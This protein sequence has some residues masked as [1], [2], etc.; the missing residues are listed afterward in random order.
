MTRR[1]LASVGALICLF[2]LLSGCSRTLYRLR[3]DKEVK[4]LVTQKSNDERW[5]FRDFTIGMDPRS[6]YFDPNDPDCP[7]MPYDDPAAHRYMHCAAGRKGYPCWHMNGDNAPI[8]NP[9]WKELL[10]QYNELTPEGA[11]K[12]T[13]NGSVCLAQVHSDSWRDQIENIYLSALDVSAER[14]SFDAQFFGDSST[15]FNH[16]GPANSPAGEQNTLT[17]GGAGSSL[18]GSGVAG[19]PGAATFA[20]TKQFT[21]GATLLVGFANAFVWQ[22]AGHD[23]NQASSL[24][25]VA[26]MQP[27][28]RNG[29]RQ[30][31]MEVL[32]R[33]ERNLLY[34]LRQWERYRQSFYC[35]ATVGLQGASG[36]QAVTRQGGLLGGSGLTGFTG[37]GA[38]GQGGIGVLVS[39]G[40]TGIGGAGGIGTGAG[41]AGGGAGSVG[42]FV[43]LI[44]QLYGVRVV[45]HNVNALNR[46]LGLLEANL[47][48]GLIDIVQV[49][50]FR[51][52]IETQR[53]ALI[54]AQLQFQANLD[55]FKT[56]IMTL[57]P[58]LSI[59]IDDSMLRPF[60]FLDPRTTAVQYMVD[61]FV[62]VLGQLPKEP[63]R[64]DVASAIDVLSQLRTRIVGQF[65]GANADVA[66]LETK[67]ETRKAAMD[68][69]AAE[70]FDTER[71][72][73]R[74]SLADVEKRFN[75]A[76]KVL[77]SLPGRLGS[78]SMA[79]VTDQLVG[80]ATDLSGLTQELLLIKARARVESVTTPSIKLASEDALQIARVN[81]LDW[82]NQRA[83]LVDSW[84][85]IAF[86]AQ[87]LKAGVNLTF[88]GG[89]GTLGNNA[90]NFNGNT[91]DLRVGV[92]FDAPLTRRLERN[93][94]RIALIGYQSQRRVTYQFEDSVNFVLR[95]LLRTLQFLEIDLEIQRRAVVIAIRRVD[96]TREDLTR[97]PAPVQPG[98]QV[99]ALGPTVAQNLIFALN[100]LQNAQNA[101]ISVVLNHYE[102]RMLL[103]REL[104][105]M[106]LDNCGMW[107][108]KPF[109]SAEWLNRDN[110]ND[111][112]LPP[113]VPV[114]W[115]QD[116]GVSLE[117]IHEFEAE[118]AG[119]TPEAR[120]AALKEAAD[121]AWESSGISK[122]AR[123]LRLMPNEAWSVKP[124]G[125]T[126]TKNP[127]ETETKPSSVHTKKNEAEPSPPP[128]AGVSESSPPTH[129]TTITKRAQAPRRAMPIAPLALGN[130]GERE[131]SDMAVPAL[132]R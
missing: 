73:L 59:E 17:V 49:D 52:N 25:N 42:G 128:P 56:G 80:L 3:A 119:D 60:E 6:R 121:V 44:Q 129:G 28:L 77:D 71:G 130:E 2:L 27:L 18:A 4:Y 111:C 118:H 50:N 112:A 81:R 74:E 69:R 113:A 110:E 32:T 31:V 66:K 79:Q 97:P 14:F 127:H 109:N 46:T 106:E 76:Q 53:A 23:T 102:N 89:I 65:R 122:N 7:A 64:Q 125:A 10:G 104:G 85:L 15:V 90:V 35:L 99:E 22:F 39:A 114:E 24:L 34:D 68:A 86:N 16:S 19:A 40:A 98:Q 57:P 105:I 67:A 47:D 92:A 75:I 115:L 48:A 62:H 26:F 5:D 55:N 100:D 78:E 45:Q 117:D 30:L 120:L 132:R 107:I 41:F 91:G 101:F 72:K 58:D 8:E 116:A 83:A 87:Q 29:G 94:Y 84:R 82:M 70:S 123:P 126:T 63:Q 33:V 93:N 124:L 61:D 51:Q 43:G 1:T 95:N 12:L 37:Q 54:T 21:T 96:K 36:V 9:R 11:I 20:M 131:P 108:D 38:N 103:Y 13:M 88:N